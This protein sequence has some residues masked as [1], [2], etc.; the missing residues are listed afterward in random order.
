MKGY[1]SV[2]IRRLR[3]EIGSIEEGIRWTKQ[4]LKYDP[5]KEDQKPL[6]KQL[7]EYEQNL[8]SAQEELAAQYAI[9]SQAA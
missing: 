4:Y 8:A 7:K 2:K 6:K 5:Y 9:E 3:E 1:M